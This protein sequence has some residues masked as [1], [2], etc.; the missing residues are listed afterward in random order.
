MVSPEWS[1]CQI[2]TAVSHRPCRWLPHLCT[3]GLFS[4]Y[5]IV[6]C[7]QAIPHVTQQ[8]QRC[9]EEIPALEG[10]GL[11]RDFICCFYWR[12]LSLTQ[13]ASLSSGWTEACRALKREVK[14]QEQTEPCT[15]AAY[16]REHT[17][18]ALC[19]DRT[20]SYCRPLTALHLQIF[21]WH[22]FKPFSQLP[23][24]TGRKHQGS[25]LLSFSWGLSST[26]KGKP[27]NYNSV[28][29]PLS[30]ENISASSEKN[31]KDAEAPGGFDMIQ[32]IL[33]GGKNKHDFFFLREEIWTG[34]Q[35]WLQGK[36]YF[37]SWFSCL[38]PK[39]AITE[40][41]S[42]PVEA[43]GTDIKLRLPG[44]QSSAISTRT[45]LLTQGWRRILKTEVD[46]T[47]KGTI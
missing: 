3:T 24:A 15:P 40:K 25:S 29:G 26:P 9:S 2:E 33:N 10:M 21:H 17:H 27:L 20:H 38:K 14:A 28:L 42:E 6:V 12:E 39:D 44:S 19:A 31:P 46:P 4:G 34:T 18:L 13:A 30:P 8:R 32:C 45:A 7:L 37:L 5:I 36:N 22:S 23:N 35:H 43:S 1:R 41:L 47:K 11:L 16:C